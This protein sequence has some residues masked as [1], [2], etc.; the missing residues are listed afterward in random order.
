MNKSIL[1][2]LTSIVF[3]S[4]CQERLVYAETR[5]KSLEALEIESKVTTALVYTT[6]KDTDKRLSL[7]DELTFESGVQPFETEVSIFVNPDKRYQKV[8]GFGGA[9]TDASSEVFSKLPSDKQEELL[10]A[11]FSKDKGI[12][13]TLV[14]TSIHSSDFGSESHTY[15]VEGDKTLDTFTIDKD[16]ELRIPFIK[17]AT[18]VAGGAITFYASPWSA[19][20]VHED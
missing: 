15:I 12:G 17:R 7:T 10:N 8:L 1:V 20:A 5:N 13:Y 18:E 19:P 6:A 4:G 9:I 16:R 11:Y 2:V 14:R 3:L